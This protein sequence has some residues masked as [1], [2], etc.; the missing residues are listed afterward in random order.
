ML[1]EAPCFAHAESCF[2]RPAYT[3][4]FSPDIE[5][6]PRLVPLHVQ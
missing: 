2:D 4:P 1:L 5:L 6:P 3:A